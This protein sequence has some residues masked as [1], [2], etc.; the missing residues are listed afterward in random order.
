MSATYNWAYRPGITN[1]YGFTVPASADN[2][3]PT[4]WCYVALFGNDTTGNGSRQ[5]P[6]RTIANAFSTNP[7]YVVLGSGV[8]RQTANLSTNFTNLIGDGDVTIDVSYLGSLFTVSIL[9][10]GF[11]NLHIK[12]NGSGAITLGDYNNGA[13]QDCYLDGIGISGRTQ[14]NHTILNTIIANCSAILHL[15]IDTTKLKNTTFIN[16][17]NI[18][19]YNASAIDSSIFYYCNISGANTV[20]ATIS[21][22]LF[23]QCNFNFNGTGSGGA[24]YP[25]TPPGYTYYSTI[26]ALQSAYHAIYSTLSFIG[27]IITDPLFNNFNIGDYSLQFSSPAKNLSYLGT[28]AG[29]KSIAYPVKASATEITGSFDFSTNVNLNITDNSI[30]LADPTQNASIQTKLIINT[31]GRQIQKFPIYGFN[32]DRNGQYIDSIPDL[33]TVANNPGDMLDVVAS[34]LVTNGAITYNGSVYQ[35]G[36]RLTTIAGVTTFTSN[37]N[38]TLTEILEAPERHTIM[39]RFS[40]GSGTVATGSALTAGYWYYIQSGSV[41]YNSVVFS[42]GSGFKAIDTNAYTGTGSVVL[43]LSTETFQHYEP[44]IQPTSNNVGDTRIGEIIRGNGDPAYVRGGYGVQEFPINAQFIQLYYI[45][46][47]S[48]L[49]P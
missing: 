6:Y 3:Q 33:A 5:Y 15:D 32:A 4:G 13:E 24:L 41:T 30:T 31:T 21:Y 1:K 11:Y 16:C 28:Y 29:A 37:A 45:I 43:A 8:Y 35:P 10:K 2:V 23:Y 22:S 46:N 9:S 42:A 14:D 39:A 36:D 25:S 38:G 17:N 34:Y 47:V 26:A 27:C 48:N 20:M 12:G 19:L 40:N 49:K 44:G 18:Q 7:T